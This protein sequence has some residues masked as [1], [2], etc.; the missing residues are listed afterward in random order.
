L[1]YSLETNAESI[2]LL[3]P[4]TYSYALYE[5]SISTCTRKDMPSLCNLG[6]ILVTGKYLSMNLEKSSFVPKC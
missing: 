2:S 1:Y 4:K 3:D 5:D 6:D